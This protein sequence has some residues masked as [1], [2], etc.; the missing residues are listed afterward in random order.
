MLFWTNESCDARPHQTLKRHSF[1]DTWHPSLSI[2]GCPSMRVAKLGVA[3]LSGFFILRLDRDGA[4][5]LYSC[6]R[7]SLQFSA[8]CS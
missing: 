3:L 6:V 4:F 2:P 8:G 7:N 5:V 1:V